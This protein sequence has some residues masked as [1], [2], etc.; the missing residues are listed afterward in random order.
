MIRMPARGRLAVVVLMLCS[1]SVAAGE[2]PR[3]PDGWASGVGVADLADSG[4]AGEAAASQAKAGLKGTPAKVVV[5]GA[6]QSQ[7]TPELIAGVAKHFSKDIIYGCL[8][9][10][11]LTAVS[12][13]PDS[14]NIDAAVGVCV[15]ALGGDVDVAVETVVTDMDDDD[16][17]YNA[18]VA[19][20]EKIR[21]AVEGSQ[22]PGKII[23]TFGD[24]YNGNNKDLASGLNEGLGGT[25]A[26]VGVAAGNNDALEIVRGEIVK[27]TNVAILVAGEFRIGQA[28]NGGTHT[29]ETAD[30]T[31]GEAIADVDGEEPFFAL[32]F[33]CRRRRQGM[34]ERQQL[35]QELEVIKKHLPGV[36]FFGL[37]G[38]GE[39]GSKAFGKPAEG[40][41]FT[42]TAA[43]FVAK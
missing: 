14:K 13:F 19:L 4:A 15:W 5:V 8:T 6:A 37:Y 36:E 1:L 9:T 39:I 12:N 43:V 38:P 29:P 27:G 10:S 21:P 24:Q 31:L 32:I 20:G 18:G 30:R 11:P 35:G 26:V 40:V 42:V 7:V 34:L 41:G 25:Y 2:G 3:A 23:V 28:L 33:N 17:Y 16:S 22:R